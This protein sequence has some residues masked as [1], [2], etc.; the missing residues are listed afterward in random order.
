MRI[1]NRLFSGERPKRHRRN[2]ENND[3]QL[4]LDCLLDDT[5]L[6]SVQ[7]KRVRAMHTCD[8]ANDIQP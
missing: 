1:S 3:A 7:E 4:A 6:R 2:L 8:N 5:G